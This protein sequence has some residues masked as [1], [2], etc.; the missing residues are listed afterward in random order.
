MP[1]FV[2]ILLVCLYAVAAKFSTAAAAKCFVS[3][4][5]CFGYACASP[6][7]CSVSYLFATV[8]SYRGPAVFLF[9]SSLSLSLSCFMGARVCRKHTQ[10]TKK[11]SSAKQGQSER[12]PQ[13]VEKKRVRHMI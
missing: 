11:H 7:V 12:K 10:H 5:I 1:Q 13:P 4:M 2:M 3:D 8:V 9:T 6:R